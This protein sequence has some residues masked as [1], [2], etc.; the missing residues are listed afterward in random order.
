VA[1]LVPVASFPG[2][3]DAETAQRLLASFGIRSIVQADDAGGAYG[4]AF[5]GGRAKVLVQAKDVKRARE[6]LKEL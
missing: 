5:G 4:L 2:R 3:L 6:A 1:E